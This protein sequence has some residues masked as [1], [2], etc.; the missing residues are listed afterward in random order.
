MLGTQLAGTSVGAPEN[1]RATYLSATH[2]KHFGSH[3]QY[4]V[5]RQY[6]KVPGH[7]LHDGAQA[8]LGS[9]YG[10]PGTVAVAI[11]EEIVP[12]AEWATAALKSGDAV[13]IVRPHSGG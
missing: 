5:E 9:A 2:G 6:G 10:D 8:I 3:V 7:E 12:R 13:E 1:D 11:N 4:L